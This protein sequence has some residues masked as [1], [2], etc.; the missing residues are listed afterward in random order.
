MATG[1]EPGDVRLGYGTNTPPGW[2]FRPPAPQVV[3]IA[4]P[5]AGKVWTYDAPDGALLHI[6]SVRA[7]LATSATTG[8]RKVLLVVDSQTGTTLF[9]VF[10]GLGVGA[11][12]S[13]FVTFVVKGT[14]T[15]GTA[16]NLDQEF[17]DLVLPGG[18]K[19]TMTVA[20]LKAGD[21]LST[22]VLTVQLI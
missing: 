5:G 10:A 4:E 2:R 14:T 16:S 12:R 11:S 19:L 20:N 21:Q 22:I 7:K 3:K 1:L 17:P 8:T 6:L 18:C 9:T 13:V 15:H